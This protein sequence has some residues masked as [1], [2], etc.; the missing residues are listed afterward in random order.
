MKKVF[1]LATTAVFMTTANAWAEDLETSSINVG[2]TLQQLNGI[3]V[4]QHINHGTMTIDPRAVNE[5]ED[6]WINLDVVS[7]SQAEHPNTDI[8]VALSGGQQGIFTTAS[9]PKTFF[10]QG[11]GDRQSCTVS[12]SGNGTKCDFSDAVDLGA[13]VQFRY[14]NLFKSDG[15][16]MTISALSVTKAFL[17]DPANYKTHTYTLTLS[18]AN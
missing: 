18:Y 5:A 1:L 10:V 2:F 8:V 7:G 6:G 4:E 12:N 17:K 9:D 3:N 15:Q 14:I 16:W 11:T 13:E